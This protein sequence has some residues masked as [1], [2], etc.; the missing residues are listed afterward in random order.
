[1]L[2]PLSIG[3][4]LVLDHMKATEKF[5]RPAPRYT[6]ASLVKKLE[7]MGIGRPS[8]YAPTISTIQKRQYVVKEARQG[9]ERDYQEL[10]LKDAKIQHQKLVEI[11]GAEKSKLFP[12]NTGMIVTDFLVAHFPNIIDFSFTAQVEEQFDSI[13][14]GQTV[15]NK[16]IQE[17]YRS[18]HE[19]VV[20]TKENVERSSVGTARVLGTHPKTGKEIS[21][22]LGKFGPYV[23]LGS[24]DDE[25]KPS[26]A[27]LRHGQYLEN[28]TIEDAL[29]L[30]KLPRRVG[31][32]EGK[33]ITAAI[34]KFGPYVR[35]D[36]KFVSLG[37]EM[38]PLTIDEATAVQ[39]IKDKRE[40]DA[41]KLIKE[42][43]QEPE[44]KVLNG[45]WGPYISFKKSNY[46]I[47]KETNA[48]ELTYEACIELIENQPPPRGKGKAPA[49]KTASAPKAKSTKAAKAPSK[50]K[51]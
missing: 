1:M 21:A 33:D 12:T 30:F 41:K 17:F 8:T 37:K 34:G 46:K 50:K 35:H 14:N 23:Q 49:K 19:T 2:P 20:D 43:D 27:S 25:E 22:K 42:F 6:E 26:Y 47:P 18:F 29:E 39:L 4:P 45:R 13:A 51:S 48:E 31:E 40:A 28:I 7:E 11:T 10:T 38:D 24:N 36:G 44:L 16:M 3:Q 15:W 32:F 9:K 5:T